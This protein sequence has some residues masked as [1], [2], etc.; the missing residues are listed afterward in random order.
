[1]Q[2]SEAVASNSYHLAPQQV[3]QLGDVEGIRR[4]KTLSG[5]S[6]P[7]GYNTVTAALRATW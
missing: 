1:M 6:V 5:T 7:F 4:T 3:R 2:A